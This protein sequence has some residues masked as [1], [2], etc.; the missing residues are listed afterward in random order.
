MPLQPY[1]IL[2]TAQEVEGLNPSEVT[3]GIAEM[4]FLFLFPV[5]FIVHFIVL[6]LTLLLEFNYYN[7]YVFQTIYNI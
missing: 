6:Y 2:I 7:C 1:N 4:L 3:K 5:H